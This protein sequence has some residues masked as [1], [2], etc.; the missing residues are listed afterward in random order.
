MLLLS[1]TMIERP[2]HMPT[3]AELEDR[4]NRKGWPF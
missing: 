4:A 3:E 2:A 1:N